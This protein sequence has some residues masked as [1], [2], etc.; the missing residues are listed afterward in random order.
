MNAEIKNIFPQLF[1]IQLQVMASP[2]TSQHKSFWRQVRATDSQQ[3]AFPCI[4]WN[5]RCK[6]LLSKN[7]LTSPYSNPY[8]YPYK[9]LT[10]IQN[11]TIRLLV[12]LNLN[13]PVT[14]GALQ[15]A[16]LPTLA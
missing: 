9:S 4:D 1:N 11:A 8:S 3:T 6:S 16:K 5:A 14:L 2:Y 10:V 13:S 15:R 12:S 7:I